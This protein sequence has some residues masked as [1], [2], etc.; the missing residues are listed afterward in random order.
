MPRYALLLPLLFGLACDGSKAV[1]PGGASG[2]ELGTGN[3]PANPGN[4]LV[5]RSNDGIFLSS[6]DEEHGLV[7][8]HYNTEDIDFCGGGTAAPTAEAQIVFTPRA[9]IYTWKTGV[10]PVYVYLLSEVPPQDVS[11]SFCSDL[12]TKW[13]YKGTH[14]LK[15][16]DN[17]LFFEPGRTDAFGWRAQGTVLDRQGK[18]YSYMESLQAAI[19]PVATGNPPPDDIMGVERHVKYSL[20]IR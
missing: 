1:A 15:N 18:A 12:K 5:F 6:V 11:A 9:A 17:N 8:R 14:T 19:T 13:I 2:A 10:L 16:T 3:G 20:T 4:S 7:V